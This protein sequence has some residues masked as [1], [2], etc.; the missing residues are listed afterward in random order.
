MKNGP[1]NR[2][3]IK[4]I[5][6]VTMTMNHVARVFIEPG[7]WLYEIFIYIGYFTAPV[8]CFFLVEG[9]HYTGSRA[10]YG[11][12]LLIFAAVSELPFCMAFSE[13]FAGNTGIAYCGMNMIFTLL[14]CFCMI[15]ALEDLDNMLLKL[16]IV[17][18]AFYL[19]GYSDW[20]YMA[21]LFALLFQW[22]GKDEEKIKGAFAAAI[23]L[24]GL[25]RFMSV[26]GIYTETESLIYALKNMAGPA[27]AGAA[28]VFG[29]NGR[30]MEKGRIFSKWF[31][32]IYYPAHL[33]VLG[34]IRLLG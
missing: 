9:Y 16:A 30:R 2:D 5:A 14:L 19:S 20:S 31:F 6:M 3:V 33:T 15:W 10:K 1:L 32:Y 28:I 27:L 24:Q 29:Y 21:P 23:L 7:T 18:G 4:Y 8:M 12:R 11:L 22:A 13:V 25:Y 26:Y 34:L 17:F